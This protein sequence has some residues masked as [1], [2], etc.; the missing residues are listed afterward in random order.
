MGIFRLMMEIL[1]LMYTQ[2]IDSLGSEGLP[3]CPSLFIP[4]SIM[5]LLAY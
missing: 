2:D 4:K 5:T 3:R 1:S